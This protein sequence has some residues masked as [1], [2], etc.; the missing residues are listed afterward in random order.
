VLAPDPGRIA[1]RADYDY[2]RRFIRGED[3]R[4]LKSEPGFIAARER[5]LAAIYEKE[6]A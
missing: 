2:G 5:L 3:P 4:A 1:F 6:P